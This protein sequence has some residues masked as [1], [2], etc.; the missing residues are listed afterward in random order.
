MFAVPKKGRLWDRVKPLIE[1]IGLSY[2]RNPRLDIALVT[3]FEN[4]V[5]V[6][7]PAA[8]IALYTSLG[9]VDM[10]ITGEDIVHETELSMNLTCIVKSKLAFGK[11]RLCLQTPIKDNIK[12]PKLLI[13]K[14]IATSFP[15]TTKA[16]FDGL[17]PSKTGTT[18]VESVTG[19]VEVACTL[20]L[21]DA[22]VD[23]VETGNTMRASGLEELSTLVTSEACFVCNP[24]TKYADV[25]DKLIKRIN[26]VL[27]AERFLMVEYNLD[28]S[29]IPEAKKITPGKTSPTISPLDNS[30]FCAIKV[31]VPK[32]DINNVMDR[33][34]AIG[35]IDI[36][37]TEIRNCRTQ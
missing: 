22:I 34:E 30:T 23:L 4:L 6:F 16:Y 14:R 9:R 27:T 10:G 11:C 18:V 29:L 19:S 20:G 36:I 37:V 28:R 13:G 31:M 3:N 24:K 26:G 2:T 7:L 1:N 17:D 15:A 5:L 12:D 35:A 21:A 25:A 8:D 33:L 32:A